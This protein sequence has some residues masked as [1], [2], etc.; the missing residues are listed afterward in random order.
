MSV[1]PCS[2]VRVRL[3]D[4]TVVGSTQTPMT[5]LPPTADQIAG[6]E[7]RCRMSVPSELPRVVAGD[8]PSDVLSDIVAG[9]RIDLAR[10]RSETGEAELRAALADMDPARDPMA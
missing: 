5:D 3:G 9:V 8:L 1:A 7:G 10:R 4:P 2:S 6:L